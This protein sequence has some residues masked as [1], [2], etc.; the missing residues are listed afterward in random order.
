MTSV[1]ITLSDEQ[2]KQLDTLAS[3]LGIAPDEL[4]QASIKELLAPTS[5]A[6][7]QAVAHVL[8]KN[9]DLYKRLA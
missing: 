2:T 7:E 8:Q 5:P 6:V 1:T 3:Q 9:A 4:I